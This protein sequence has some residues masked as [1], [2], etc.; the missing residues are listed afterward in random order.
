MKN[1]LLLVCL[2]LSLCGPAL[3]QPTIPKPNNDPYFDGLYVVQP[4]QP[5]GLVLRPGDRLAICGDSITEQKMYSRIMETYLTVALPELNIGTRQY[6]WS[7]EQA[8]GLLHRMTND[9]LRFDPTVATTCYGMNDHHYRPYEPAIGQ[10]YASN[11][12]DI[13]LAFEAAGCRVIVGSP[14]CM[15]LQ[16]PPWNNIQGTPKERNINLCALRD[17]DIEIAQVEHVGFADVFWDMYLAQYF[18]LQWYGAN[19]T[20]AGKDSVHPGWAGHLVMAYAFLKGLDVPGDIGTFTVNLTSGKATVSKGHE[21][22][23][24]RDG[25]L[26]IKSSRYPFCATGEADK[27][28]SIR[29]GMTLVPFNQDLNRLMLV[30]KGGKAPHYQITWGPTSRTYSVQQLS[31]GVNLAA[32][33]PAN[34]FSGA[35]EAVDQAVARKQDFETRQIKNLFHGEAGKADMEKTVADSEQERAPLVAAIKEAF[36]PVTHTLTI[37]PQ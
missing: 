36:V 15:G 14:G 32:D 31:T 16:N 30:V 4:P 12:T 23:S 28:D 2:S 10:V 26:T 27:A 17:I 8:S 20:L 11:M 3:A 33:F 35:F 22:I 13:V 29:S 5:K 9:V 7:G 24:C 25:V 34:P 21:L 6:G 19:Y 18:A 37:T 1:R